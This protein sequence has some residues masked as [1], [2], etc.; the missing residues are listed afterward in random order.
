M[1]SILDFL[2]YSKS[3]QHTQVNNLFKIPKKEK[4]DEMPHIK[5]NILEPNFFY[6]CDILYLPTARF[7]FKYC[8]VIVDVY[9]SKCDA[10]PLKSKTSEA[11]KNAL[12][13]I[14]KRD[15]LEK[16]RIIQFDQGLEFKGEVQNFCENNNIVAKYTLTNRHRQNANV[17]AKNK[18]IGG[19]IMRYLNSKEF[20][21][22]KA[23]KNWIEQ[24]PPL[25]KYLNEHLPR[26]EKPDEEVITTN[27]SKDL[28]PLGTHVRPILDYPISSH[29]EKRIDSKFRTGDMRWNPKERI[30]E[31]IIL[32]PQ[33][34]PMYQLNGTKTKI[35]SSVAYTKNQLQIVDSKEIKIEKSKK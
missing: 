35:D 1:S 13:K 19:I 17:E 11:V 21:D 3:K 12:E 22:K 29:N 31:K 14:L 30:V 16:P 24:L 25:I 2:T 15:I 28:I 23:K 4:Y 26:R 34:P 18:L 27:Y 6:E 20:E 10:Q 33:E 8:L 32:N 7:G 9:N 5:N